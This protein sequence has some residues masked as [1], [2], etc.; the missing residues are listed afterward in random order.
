MKSV[1]DQDAQANFQDVLASAQNERVVITRQGKPSAVVLG[2]ESCDEADLRLAV[3]P[4]FW[5]MIQLRRQGNS[6][7]L[8]ELK[9]RLGLAGDARE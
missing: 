1:S 4:E 8:A 5:T 6:I 7:P 2:L 3:S 9:V